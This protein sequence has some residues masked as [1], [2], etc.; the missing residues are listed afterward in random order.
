MKASE[1]FLTKTAIKGVTYMIVKVI[2]WH[3]SLKCWSLEMNCFNIGKF[4]IAACL[5]KIH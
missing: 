5:I 2:Y 4:G 1:K 3:S